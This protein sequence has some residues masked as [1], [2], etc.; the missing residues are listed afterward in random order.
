MKIDDL[1][2]DDLPIKSPGGSSRPPIH[3]SCCRSC[4]CTSKCHRPH[5]SRSPVRSPGRD[6]PN[7]GWFGISLWIMTLGYIGMQWLP[8]THQLVG[9]WPSP[10]KNMKVSWGYYSQY[11]GNNNANVPNHQPAKIDLKFKVWLTPLHDLRDNYARST[12]KQTKE[13]NMLL[14]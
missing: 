1:Q 6:H 14:H 11:D 2:Y 10:L 12:Q 13:R 9:G 8:I 4:P 5:A 3:G 7:A